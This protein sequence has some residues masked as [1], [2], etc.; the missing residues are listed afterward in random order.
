ML[1]SEAY[2]AFDLTAGA[3]LNSG[4]FVKVGSSVAVFAVALDKS[5]EVESTDSIILIYCFSAGGLES[6]QSLFDIKLIIR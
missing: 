6:I 4:E 5:F 3:V 1:G 2:L